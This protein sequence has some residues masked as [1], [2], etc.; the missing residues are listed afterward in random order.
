MAAVPIQPNANAAFV[1][2]SLSS[3]F[4]AAISAGTASVPGATKAT[5]AHTATEASW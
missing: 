4:K 1:R 3:S 5:S 2:I